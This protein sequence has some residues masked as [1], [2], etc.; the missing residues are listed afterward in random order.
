M[1]IC[2]EI[3]IIILNFKQNYEMKK[4]NNRLK[5]TLLE[6]WYEYKKKYIFLTHVYYYIY[7]IYYI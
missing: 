7:Y 5:I 6:F 3:I 1:G 2:Y 4:K